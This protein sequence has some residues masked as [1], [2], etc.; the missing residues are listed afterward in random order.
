M[1]LFLNIALALAAF[2]L[3]GGEEFTLTVLHTNDTHGRPLAFDVEGETA[4]GLA[5][6]KTAVDLLRSTEPNVL[7]LDAGDV[8]D[9]MPVSNMNRVEPDFVGMKLVGYDA[10]AVGNHEFSHD[11]ETILGFERIGGFPLLCANLVRASDGTRPFKPHVILER[12]GRRIA[13][14]GFIT[15]ELKRLVFEER[16]AGLRVRD[17]AAVARELVP[18]L[19]EEADHVIALSHC[20]YGY[21]KNTLAAVDGIDLIVG[22]HSHTN[23]QRPRKVG[24]TVVVQ[25]WRHG[26]FVGKVTL[27]FEGKKLASFEGGLVPVNWTP[28]KADRYLMLGPFEENPEVL[29]RLKPY[30]EKLADIL[31]RVVGEVAKPAV[32]SKPGWLDRPFSNLAADAMRWAAG[33]DA[34]IQNT[35]GVRTPIGPGPVTVG[36]IKTMLPFMNNVMVVKL[37]GKVLLEALDHAIFVSEERPR[38]FGALSGI[39]VVLSPRSDRIVSVRVAGEPL[40]EERVYTVAIN[41]YMYQRGDDYAMFL[42]NEG[43]EDL[44]FLYADALVRYLEARKT[45]TPS[46]EGRIRVAEGG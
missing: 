27:R 26:L 36:Q 18:G 37:K 3:P 46:A 8:S 28:E 19:R 35:G 22:G 13:V 11:V 43:T 4:G 21:D 24:N 20:G 2:L 40:D 32:E 31:D 15:P 14:I 10:M 25:A 38:T 44:G 6:R 23:L 39:E 33:A 42:N 16:I 29:A 30:A 12:G 9:G 45:V 1:H 17:P 7:L 41:S 5:A 34:A